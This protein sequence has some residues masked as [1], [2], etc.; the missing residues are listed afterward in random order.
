MAREFDGEFR[1]TFGVE[2][3][4]AVAVN[5]RRAGGFAH[6]LS[7]SPLVG[8]NPGVFIP[9]EGDGG[10]RVPQATIGYLCTVGPRLGIIAGDPD[11]VTEGVKQ[12]LNGLL[13]RTAGC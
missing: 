12:Q 9:I 13:E 7:A 6:V 8:V 11:V 4:V 10:D 1:A 2:P 5:L 3:F